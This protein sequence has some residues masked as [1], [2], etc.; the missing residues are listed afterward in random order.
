MCFSGVRWGHTFARPHH[1][2]GR[3]ARDRRVFFVEAPLLDAGSTAPF[4]E[5]LR[6]PD[7]LHVCVPHLSERLSAHAAVEAERALVDRLRAEHRVA[8]QIAWL[9]P[10]TALELAARLDARCTVYDCVDDLPRDAALA[11][12]EREVVG[13]SDL[14]LTAG[15]SLWASTR[16]QHPRVHAL[17][18]GIDTAH[19]ARARGTIEEPRD[20]AEIRGPRLG[21]VGTVDARIDLELVAHVADERP[22][23][24][25]VIVGP[26]VGLDP[27]AL[28]RRPNIH[29]LGPKSYEQLPAYL[30]GWDVV[31]MPLTLGGETR[32]VSP[33]TT[34]E[35]LAAGKPVVSTAAPDLEA[36]DGLVRL[37]DRG[38]F[39]IAI[40]S[41]LREDRTARLA[42]ADELLASTS[43]ET[44]FEKVRRLVVDVLAARAEI[45]A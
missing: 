9:Y 12:L 23:F 5:V 11:R 22:E 6:G 38:S 32:F 13:R 3:F 30:S 28:P 36:P 21:L 26:I 44:T 17:P 1:L 10:P 43:W 34:L 31:L 40:E 18:S 14:V 39:V 15:R 45:A 27:R 4:L 41:A 33:A 35:A 37:A 2:M 19:F 20:Q 16:H 24:Q 42:R 8:A 25:V 7:G 29:W